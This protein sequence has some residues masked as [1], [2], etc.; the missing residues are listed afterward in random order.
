MPG[1]KQKLISMPIR[2]AE[3]HWT[4]LQA[5]R[6]AD[7]IAIQEHVRRALTAYIEA[8]NRK[9]QK[10]LL[11]LPPL[12]TPDPAANPGLT[13]GPPVRKKLNIVYR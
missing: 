4:G 10:A 9:Q 8:W 6:I 3:S 1:V 13:A 7:G 12:P 5:M 2:I 11:P